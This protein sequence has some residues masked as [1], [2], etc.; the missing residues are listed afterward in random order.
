[1]N[2]RWVHQKL[3]RNRLASQPR[4]SAT[5]PAP[6]CGL[7]GPA[8]AAEVRRKGPNPA[9]ERT[10]VAPDKTGFTLIELLVVISIMGILA[11]IGLPALKGFGQ[12]NLM[13]A[14]SGQLLGD[15]HFARMVALSQRTTV[16]V[17]FVPPTVADT[18]L[19]K[20]LKLDPDPRLTRQWTNLVRS[21]Y[22]SYALYTERQVGA[23]PGQY[24]PRYLTDWKSLPDGVFIA[25]NKFVNPTNQPS[26]WQATLPELRSFSPP[27]V[28]P[29]PSTYS[30][31]TWPLPYLAFTPQGQLLR[32]PGWQPF[33]HDECIPLARG[34]I[35]YQSDSFGK[36]SADVL[37]TPPGNSTNTYNRI[38]I[39]WITGRARFEKPEIH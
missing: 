15:L 11:M 1:M 2:Q 33:Y 12:G 6:A 25:T 27:K 23:Q 7:N 21:Q 5:E 32:P 24:S 13:K 38:H 29:F 8:G 9:N 4:L 18:S 10:A 37:E 30:S 39:N 26:L 19:L 34:S 35:L 31:R 28:F 3:S 22:T 36:F 20:G 14:A 17:V 16:Y